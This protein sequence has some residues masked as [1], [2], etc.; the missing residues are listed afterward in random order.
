MQQL[1]ALLARQ[2]GELGFDLGRERHD[3]GVLAAAAT[4]SRNASR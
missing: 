4:A 2:L 3:L 1:D